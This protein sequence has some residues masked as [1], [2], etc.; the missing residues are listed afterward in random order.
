[1]VRI[2]GLSCKGIVPIGR[3]SYNLIVV[4]Y[5]I[6]DEHEHYIPHSNYLIA[7][8]YGKRKVAKLEALTKIMSFI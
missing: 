8:T 2:F 4:T 5:F 7:K 3:E 1:M 6:G